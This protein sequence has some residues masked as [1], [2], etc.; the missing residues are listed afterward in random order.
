MEKKNL[1]ELSNNEL[2]IYKETLRNQYE[3]LQAKIDTL[4][5]ELQRVEKE[6]NKVQNETKIRTKLY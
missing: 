5:N 4:C 3:A 2:F 6:Y 1:K